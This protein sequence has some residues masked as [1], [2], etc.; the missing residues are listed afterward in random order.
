MSDQSLEVNPGYKGPDNMPETVPFW[1]NHF[2]GR[3]NSL[4]T[5]RLVGGGLLRRHSFIGPLTHS[6]SY[7]K[8]KISLG[9]GTSLAEPTYTTR[10]FF[11]RICRASNL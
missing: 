8:P 2:L 9:R 11:L 5:A 3:L 1:R 7:L 4:E 10:T 6:K